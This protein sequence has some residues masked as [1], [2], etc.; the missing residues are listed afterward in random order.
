MKLS[1][2]QGVGIA[3]TKENFEA[4]DVEM[5]GDELNTVAGGGTANGGGNACGCVE[6]GFGTNE[7]T[8]DD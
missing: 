8:K 6:P 7:R 4:H 5:Y 2:C 3:F 1:P